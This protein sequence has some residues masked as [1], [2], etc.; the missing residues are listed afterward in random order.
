MTTFVTGSTGHVGANLVRALLADGDAV[1]VLLR[2]GS[3]RGP[4]A[5]LPVEIASGDLGSADALARAME[6]C[7]RVYHLAAMI[8]IRDV[9]RQRLFQVN[10]EGT[11]NVL[12]AARTVGVER[13]VHCSSF[14]TIGRNPRG[15][16]DESFRLEPDEAVM[17]YD[18]TKLMGELEVQRAAA[19]GFHVTIVNPTG[20]VGPHDYKPSRIGR[21]ILDFGHGKLPAYVTIRGG[22]DFVPVRDVVAGHRLAMERGRPGE[23][24][25]LS[26]ELASMDQIFAWLSELIGRPRPRVSIPPW[27][28]GPV[29]R[30]KDGVDRRLFPERSPNF[31]AHS[32][33]LLA[34]RKRGSSRK[35]VDELGLEPTPLRDAFV[36]AVD[37]FR[38]TGRLP[39]A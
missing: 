39:Q 35:A 6:G 17:H 13:M 4:V 9:D 11:R 8:S 1:R 14:G 38:K 27:M 7:D 31:T 25:I 26:G 32:V 19:D 3:D 5:D 33:R 2:D 18:R 30:I 37:W 12:R 10:V 20:V 22:F 28:L 29:A 15:A 34:S 24:Y 21:S 23:R 16:C 36:E